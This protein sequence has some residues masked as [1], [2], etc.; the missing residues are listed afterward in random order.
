MKIAPLLCLFIFFSC[1][2]TEVIE[3]CTETVWFL[4]ADGDGY[5]NQEVPVTA[6]EQPE[7]FVTN[8]DD[9]NDNDPKLN[10]ESIW[11]GPKITFTKP[12]N[13]S[14]VLAENQ[15]RI[16]STVWLTRAE[17]GGLINVVDET[18]FDRNSSPSNTYWARGTTDDFS[19]LYFTTF[20]AALYH[21]IGDEI[22]GTELVMYIPDEGI[23]IDFKFSRW[24]NSYE[25]AGYTYE[26]ST[27]N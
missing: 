16:A 14:F 3:P 2:K 22:I 11:S 20:R 13:S 10:P 9:F 4:D 25:G 5:G 27:P 17:S 8:F 21:D 12:S 23:F 6:C 15:D 7:N 24:E 19:D 26:R 1:T 18:F